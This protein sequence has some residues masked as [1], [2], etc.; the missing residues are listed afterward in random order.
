[1]ITTITT[2]APH[3]PPTAAPIKTPVLLSLSLSDPLSTSVM[4]L[5]T[6]IELNNLQYI[7]VQVT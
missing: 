4:Q 3:I 7:V 6:Q 5:C 2:I 1:M